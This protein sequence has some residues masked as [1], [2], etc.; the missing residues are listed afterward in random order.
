VKASNDHGHIPEIRV[1][2]MTASTKPT[3][4]STVADLRHWVRAARAAGKSIGLV[5]T[6]GALHEGHLSLARASQAECDLTVVTIF[7]NPTQFGP[8]EDFGKYPR[9]LEADLESLRTTGADLVFVPTNAEMYPADFSTYV[10]PPRSALRW[11]GEC[12]PGHF[13]GVATIVLKLFNAAQADIAFFGQKDYQQVA[14]IR[15]MVRDLDVP[16]EIRVCPTVRE[17]DG[18]AMSSRNRY[19]SLDERR[20][21]VA[22]SRGLKMAE[23]LASQGQRDASALIASVRQTLHDAGIT[24]IDYVAV[25]DSDSLEPVAELNGPAVVLIAAFVGGTRLIDNWRIGE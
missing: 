10:E 19:L 3:V 22:L 12:R 11:E 4:V 2:E 18:L 9:T 17:P 23:Q 8:Q 24:R 25:V 16:V 5:P 14:V 15:Q 21:A 6:M 1:I 13:R 20:Q 7:V